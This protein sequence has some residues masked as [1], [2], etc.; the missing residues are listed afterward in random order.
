MPDLLDQFMDSVERYFGAYE[1]KGEARADIRHDVKR[2]LAGRIDPSRANLIAVLQA[3][4]EHQPVRFGPP[5]VA[6]TCE[7]IKDYEAQHGSLRPE[8]RD[9]R[10][11]EPV[12][13]VTEEDTVDVR[14]QAEE[15]GIDTSKDGWMAKYLFS[16]LGNSA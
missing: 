3:M 15:I 6:T 11:Y 5:D 10:T 16:H 7:A 12:E 1:I 9:A 8:Y 4:K 13:P 2:Y 14:R